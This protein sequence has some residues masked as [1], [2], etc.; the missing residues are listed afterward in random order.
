MTTRDEAAQACVAVLDEKFFK[1]FSEPVRVAIFREV[2]IL[3]EADVAAISERF[4]QDR[5]VVS[6]HLQLLADA[7]I[8]TAAKRGRQVFYSVNG[9]RIGEK[10]EAILATIRALQPVCCPSID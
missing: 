6:R 1:A 3:G 10:L 9:V 4:P 7:E 8:L 5:S 2:V